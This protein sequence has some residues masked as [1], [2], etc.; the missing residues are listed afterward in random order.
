MKRFLYL[1]CALAFCLALTPSTALAAAPNGQ[2]IYVGNENVTSGGYWT[3]GSDGT[4]TQYTG[5]DTPADNYVHYDADTNTL[6]LHNA[7]IKKGLDYN[8]NITGGTFIIGSAI[9]VFNQNGA[10]ELTITLEGTNTIAEVG[11]G[12]YVLA[13]STGGATLTIT[14]DGSLDASSS[15]NSGILVQSNGGNATLSI[16]NAEVTTTSSSSDGVL[17]QAQE[18]SNASLSVN[19]GSLTATGSGT[20]GAGIKFQF[21]SRDYNSG[22][23]SLTVSGNAIVRANGGI[24]NNSSS[25]IQYETGSDSTGGIVFDGNTGTVHGNVTL[26]NPLTIGEGETLTIPEDSTLN[27]NN[28]LTNNGI[29]VNTGGTLNGEP[30]GTGTIETAP[31]ITTDSLSNGTVGQDY[32]QT[33]HADGGNITWSATGLPAGLTLDAAT[34]VISGTPATAEECTVTVTATN[35]AGEASKEYTLTIEA[36]PVANV[37]LDHTVLALFPGDTTALTATVEPDTATDKTVTWESSDPNV[38]TVNQSGKVTAVAPGTATITATAG[39]KTATC[40]V[41]VTPRTYTVSV[42]PTSIEFDTICPGDTQPAAQ[43]VTITNTG[44]QTVEVTLPAATGYTITGDEG[45][46]GNTASIEPEG[47]ATF[48][49]Q[50]ND[51]TAGNHSETLTISWNNGNHP[52][53]V[54]FTVGHELTGVA[55]KAPTCTEDGYEAYWKCERCNELFSDADGKTPIPAPTVI[56]ATGH[57]WGEP[58]WTWDGTTATA[59]FTCKNDASHTDIVTAAVTSTVTTDPTCTENGV[60]EYTAT[61]EHDGTTYTDTKNVTDI[62]ATG[63]DWGEDGHCTICDAVKPGFMPEIIQGD[64]ATWTKGDGQPL[65]FTSNAAYADFQEARVDGQPLDPVHYTVEQ[66]S[67]I[68]TLKAAYLESLDPGEHTLDIVSSTGTATA[69]F[70]ITAK[71]TQQPAKPADTDRTLA[72]SAGDGGQLSRSGSDIMPAVATL[73]ILMASG[74]VL[75]T[76]VLRRGRR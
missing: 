9:G 66:G 53:P 52:L 30:G 74:L 45:F 55:A 62:P 35:S 11:K 58:A 67:T 13:S 41:T 27:T 2:V 65:S 28:N 44:N 7:T 5:P 40:T 29:I 3:T 42:N 24:A 10:A 63:H 6:T 59:T 64:E 15:V 43:S 8:E 23:P 1:L 16:E 31:I 17:V 70:T 4:V 49:V 50:P 26:Q 61:V 22:T 20:Y 21:G 69:T 71:E 19:G 39:G 14:G 37:T 68:V 48:T 18:G 51:L 12:I 25:P 54:G 73:A 46:T 76:F 47:T 38:A 34:G 56:K 60:T 33:L 36:V 32:N 75:G 72:K 57:Q